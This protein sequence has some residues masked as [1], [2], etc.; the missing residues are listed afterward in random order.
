MLKSRCASKT[1]SYLVR[2]CQLLGEGLN[3]GRA[4]C[5]RHAEGAMHRPGGCT[6]HYQLTFAPPEKFNVIVLSKSKLGLSRILFW[7]DTGYPADF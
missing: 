6:R 3:H 5:P 2:A 7:L 4:N 1:N